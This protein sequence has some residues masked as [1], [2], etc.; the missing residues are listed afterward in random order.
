[1]QRLLKKILYLK[2]ARQKQAIINTCINIFPGR[3]KIFSRPFSF[4]LLTDNYTCMHKS[5]LSVTTV[6]IFSL[7]CFAQ[8]KYNP[9]ESFA[10]GFYINKGNTIRSANGAPGPHYWQNRADYSLQAT[11]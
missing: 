6:L 5:F 10:P 11:I 9:A 8:S 1:M 4:K 2:L 3:L 7:S